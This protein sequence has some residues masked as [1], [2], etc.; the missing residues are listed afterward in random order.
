MKFVGVF[1]MTTNNMS[2][3]RIN[4][5]D[6]VHNKL[7]FVG[8]YDYSNVYE[9]DMDK[10]KIKPLTNCQ[11][12]SFAIS[13]DDKEL[14]FIEMDINGKFKLST[15]DLTNGT[16]KKVDYPEGGE[17]AGFVQDSKHLIVERYYKLSGA[18]TKSH[19]AIYLINLNTLKETKIYAEDTKATSK[20]EE[21]LKK[22][23]PFYTA[24][25]PYILA[26]P[27]KSTEIDFAK[28][29]P[30]DQLKMYDFTSVVFLPYAELFSG[31][32][33][34]DL[35]SVSPGMKGDPNLGIIE[36]VVEDPATG[37]EICNIAKF[38]GKGAPTAIKVVGNIVYFEFKNGEL[39]E[40][41]TQYPPTYRFVHTMP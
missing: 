21:N 9:F 29:L 16:I 7:Y 35:S 25:K 38:P 28:S 8:G 22:V 6:M 10:K 14:V 12:A 34:A 36:Y 40:F 17:I 33:K 19:T 3:G 11:Q 30:T 4:S 23:E 5:V 15:L 20:E 2:I 13:P 1:N 31:S 24:G 26:T 39:L 18:D 32:Q 27:N 41:N 37:K